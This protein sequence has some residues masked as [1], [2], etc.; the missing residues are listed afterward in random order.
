MEIAVK[1]FTLFLL[2][3]FPGIVFRRFYY[4][5]EFSKQ[6]NSSNWL[7]TFYISL[8]PGLIIQIISYLT[9]ENLIY[10]KPII[11]DFESIN[12]IYCK[13]KNDLLPSEL[14]NFELIGWVLSYILVTIVISF[15]IAQLSWILVRNLDLDKKFS[16]LRFNNYWHYYLSG[17]ITA[18]PSTTR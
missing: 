1:S 14:F 5:G 2:F 8:V 7:N 17:E 9:F 4:V 11:T 15:I 10:K 3:I 18:F 13:I 16:P 12:S 6:F